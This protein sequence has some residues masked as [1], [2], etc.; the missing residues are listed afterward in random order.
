MATTT[1]ANDDLED[2]EP[3]AFFARILRQSTPSNRQQ[4]LL[5]ADT[6][7]LLVQCASLFAQELVSQSASVAQRRSDKSSSSTAIRIDDVKFVLKHQWPVYDS[8]S[9]NRIAEH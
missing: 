9:Y 1:T 5:Q 8:S 6:E 2:L 4:S 3:S 7:K